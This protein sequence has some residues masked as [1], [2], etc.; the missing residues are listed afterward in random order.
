MLLFG[1]HPKMT[2]TAKGRLKIEINAFGLF[3]LF[4]RLGVKFI[5][6]LQI[7]PL[8]LKTV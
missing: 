4:D 2:E 3:H 7:V 8:E 1:I 5:F 6:V